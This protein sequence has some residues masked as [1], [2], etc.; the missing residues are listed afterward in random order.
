MLENIIIRTMTIEDYEQVKKLWL[1]ISGFGIRSIDD[2]REGVS[3]FLLRNPDTSIVA[4][5]NGEIVGSIL[6]G[7]DG[8]QACFYHVCV[9]E[10]LR[11]HGIGKAMAIKAMSQLKK[12]GINKISLVAFKSNEA[13]NSFWP[14]VGWKLRDDFNTYDFVLNDHNEINFIN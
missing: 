2:S 1:S 8:R 5:L 13:G 3:R 11:C 4:E 10:E 12:E 14:K 9:K 6:C 7:H